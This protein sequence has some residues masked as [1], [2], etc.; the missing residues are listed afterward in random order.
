MFRLFLIM[1]LAAATAAQAVGIDALLVPLAELQAQQA[2][3]AADTP[4]TASPLDEA[5]EQAD[6][7]VVGPA[8]LLP[9]VQRILVGQ[10]SPDGELKLSLLKHW[11]GLRVKDEGWRVEL[12][13]SPGPALAPR[14]VVHLRLLCGDEPQGEVQLPLAC[15]VEGRVLVPRRQITRGEILDGEAFEVQVRDL[16]ASP[17]PVVPASEDVSQFELKASVGPAQQL[18][19]RDVSP[20]PLVRRGQVVELVVTEG[21]LRISCKAEALENGR[22]GDMIAVRNLS[23]RK[24]LQAR[25]IDE[26]TVQ[27]YF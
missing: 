22:A 27:V 18:M 14:M 4:E 3:P 1:W 20:R 17:A 11:R 23:S 13:R 9:V 19:W 10:Y 6:A 7:N 12:V 21:F 25:I 8:D 26:Q 16:L 2:N 5:D 15:R 24:D